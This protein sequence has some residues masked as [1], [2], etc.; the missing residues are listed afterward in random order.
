MATTSTVQRFGSPDQETLDRWA[1]RAAEDEQFRALQALK[2]NKEDVE[3][4]EQEL[5]SALSTL[6]DRQMKLNE[7][8]RKINEQ[9]KVNL[10]EKA[11][12]ER[13]QKQQMRMKQYNEH[14]QHMKQ[15]YMKQQHLQQLHLQQQHLQQIQY[16]NWLSMQAPSLFWMHAPSAEDMNNG[17][18]LLSP[19]SI[20][21]PP[22]LD[23]EDVIE[24]DASSFF[25][26]P[27]GLVHPSKEGVKNSGFVED[28]APPPGLVHP[29]KEGSDFE[30][31]CL[32]REAARKGK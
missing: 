29:S 12:I 9:K 23:C 11:K 13:M 2:K 10:I 8:E 20:P 27:P 31:W 25:L 24:N 17:Q 4:R 15:Q 19:L 30:E 3:R 18:E 32:K 1:K 28:P 22:G 7:Q 16:F 21:L 6:V 14:R 5:N 26:P